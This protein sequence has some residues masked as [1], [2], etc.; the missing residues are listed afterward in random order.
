MRP[1]VGAQPTT[2]KGHVRQMTQDDGYFH[3]T[4]KVKQKMCS[5]ALPVF[6]VVMDMFA[7]LLLSG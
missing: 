7:R 6:M 4:D 2:I 1:A 5:V 3:T